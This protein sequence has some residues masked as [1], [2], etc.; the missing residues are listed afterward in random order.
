MLTEGIVI[1][2][3]TNQ[4]DARAGRVTLAAG[5][6]TVTTTAIQAASDVI[7][8]YRTI[9]GTPGFLSVTT[10]TAAT[11]F[12]IQ[13]KN[14]AGAIETADLSTVSWMIVDPY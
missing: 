11:S 13:S 1:R 14:S 9:T 3:Y 6:V 10:I 4:T 12:V 7:L 5:Q 8:S 2:Q